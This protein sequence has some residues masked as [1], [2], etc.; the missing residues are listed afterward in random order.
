MCRFILSALGVATLYVLCAPPAVAAPRYVLAYWY[1]VGGYQNACCSSGCSCSGTGNHSVYVHVIDSDGNK[2]GNIR[3]ED[4][5][6]PGFYGITN[7]NPSDKLGYVEIPVYMSGTPALRVNDSGIPSDV[8]PEMI[9]NRAPTNGHYSWECAFMRVPDGVQVTFDP[10]LTGTPNRSGGG[11]DIH[12]PFTK[13]CSYYDL[14]P[15]NWASDQFSLDTGASSYGQTFVATGDRVVV[16]KF[17]TTVGFLQDLRYGV[18]IRENGPGGAIV[19]PQRVS[20]LMKSDEYFTQ[21]ITWPL[22][23]PNAA[24]VVPGNTYYAEITRVDQAG[25]VNIWRRNNNVYPNG[26]MYRGGSPV[27]GMD[28]IGR[29]VC[30]RT[31]PSGPTGMIAGTVT[32]NNAQ[33]LASAQVAAEPGGY[34]TTTNS[35]GQFALSSV[36]VGTYSVTASKTDYGPQ[37]QN[38]VIVSEAST[39]TVNFSLVPGATAPGTVSGTVRDLAGTPVSLASVK[40]SPGNHAAVTATDGSYEIKRVPPGTYGVTA[41]AP[42]RIEQTLSNQVLPA[43]GTLTVDFSLAASGKVAHIVDDFNGNYIFTGDTLEESF[44]MG[45]DNHEYFPEGPPAHPER[46]LPPH[47]ASDRSQKFELRTNNDQTVSYFETKS[48]YGNDR[49]LELTDL[50]NQKGWEPIDLTQPITYIVYVRGVNDIANPDSTQWYWRQRM[51]VNCPSLYAG[52]AQV[53]WKSSNNDT[54]QMLRTSATGLQDNREQWITFESWYPA[55]LGGQVIDHN[56]MVWENLTIE[57][58]PVG[59]PADTTPPGPV[60]DFTATANASSISLTWQNPPDADF[61]GTRIRYRTDMSPTGPT[62]GTLLVDHPGTPGSG[63]SFEHAGVVPG[64]TYYYAAF[65]YDEVPNY[66]GASADDASIP[67]GIPGDFDGDGDVDQEDFG[68]LQVCLSGAGVTQADAACHDARLDMDLDVDQEDFGI[69][70][71]C[72]S[73]PNVPSDPACNP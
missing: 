68:H 31:T 53:E 33:P 60:V 7:N 6:N 71:A 46:V 27:S 11:C 52:E 70:Q 48:L 13:S 62:N 37:T 40:L 28:L 8:S 17:Q 3:V 67:A 44:R 34:S 24:V 10:A 30:A 29:I 54:W 69:F 32:D 43:A 9:E 35:N 41:Y 59:G 26:Q 14:D 39:T 5:D 50:V 21:I 15:L 49:Y 36:P 57:Y 42:T 72:M 56:W 64:Q 22:T 58:T 18:T 38:N 23:G 12:A 45:F 66:S 2:L 63:G 51:G 55:W 65:A 47:N 19:G 1:E 4:A 25:N 16:A 61:V 73:G 20:R